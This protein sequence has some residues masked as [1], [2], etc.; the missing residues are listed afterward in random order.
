MTIFFFVTVQILSIC[1]SNDSILYVC[2]SLHCLVVLQIWA[3]GS[4][5]PNAGEGDI[6]GKEA[7][8]GVGANITTKLVNPA[9]E[10]CNI[11]GK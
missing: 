3:K 11:L 4:K 6:E 2:K 8:W 5:P 7:T 9:G 10:V 1:Y